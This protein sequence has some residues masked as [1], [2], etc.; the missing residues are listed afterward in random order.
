MKYLYIML[1]LIISIG[2][3]EKYVGFTEIFST[4]RVK[5]IE[6]PIEVG[7]V[8]VVESANIEDET[9]VADEH[10][11]EK[12]VKSDVPARCNMWS[13]GCNVCTRDVGDS[14]KAFCTTYPQCKNRMV[15]CLEW[16]NN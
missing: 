5:I 9:L 8:E 13:D 4:K 10:K 15:S 2:C 14:K 11:V 7:A 16:N 6:K 3:S 12:R 1:F